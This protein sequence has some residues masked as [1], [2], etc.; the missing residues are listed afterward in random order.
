MRA[1]LLRRGKL[2]TLIVGFLFSTVGALWAL[3]VTDRLDGQIQRLGDEKAAISRDVNALNRYASEY[4]IANQQGDLIYMLKVQPDGNR[5]VA[6]RIYLGNLS[7]RR[8]P[9]TNMINELGLEQ[10]LDA[11]T[12]YAAYKKAFEEL[13]DDPDN[14]EKYWG[15]KLFE[16]KLIQQG[17]NRALE[18]VDANNELDR[19]LRSKQSTQ[20]INHIMAVLTAIIG[21][22][23][24]VAA[25]VIS[26]TDPA[27]INTVQTGSADAQGGT[28]KL[29]Q[30]EPT[31]EE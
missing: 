19:Q 22:A 24:L 13:I 27:Q 4:F 28:G 16:K 9:V 6:S 25:N 26:E 12:T 3:L 15:V 29:P 7:D 31:A 11:G 8:T 17:Q 10:Q 2:V 14:E 1:F 20:S 5:D 21:S 30:T 23:V 18:L